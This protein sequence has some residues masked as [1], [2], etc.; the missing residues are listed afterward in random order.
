[1]YSAPARMEL[2]GILHRR[3]TAG[4]CPRVSGSRRLGVSTRPARERDAR[5]KREDEV[6]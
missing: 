2:D 5:I 6:I 1:M 4:T 3:K